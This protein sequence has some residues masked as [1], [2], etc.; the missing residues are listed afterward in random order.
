MNKKTIKE[1]Y[2]KITAFY[3]IN[4]GLIFNYVKTK[5]TQKDKRELIL[6]I[7][8]NLGF[9]ERPTLK[10]NLK[11]DNSLAKNFYRGLTAPNVATLKQYINNTIKGE[12]RIGSNAQIYG[13][14]IYTTLDHTAAI[15]YATNGDTSDCGIVLE[16][17]MKDDVKIA[18]YK[19]IEEIKEEFLKSIKINKLSENEKIFF[20]LIE[21]TGLFSAIM[22][23]DAVEIKEKDYLLIL[24]RSKMIVDDEKLKEDIFN[25]ENNLTI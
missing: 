17:K 10:S 3:K 16:L 8:K 9:T 4:E 25:L 7:Y 14:G 24:N 21:D 18:Q 15:K 19:E 6:E 20:N 1:I 13:K 23:Y 11:N 12:F 2:N 5:Q 22:G